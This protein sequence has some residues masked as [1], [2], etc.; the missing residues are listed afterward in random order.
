LALYRSAQETLTNIQ[1][2]AQA[3]ECWLSLHIETNMI[4]LRVT[5]NGIG[6]P[7]DGETNGFGLLGLR[8]RAALVGGK[9]VMTP[10]EGGGTQI[11]IQLPWEGD[12]TG[13]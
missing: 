2:H 13:G 12:H 8:E 7:D 6:L 9:V 5:D 3:S 10:R 1:K 11:L 4:K